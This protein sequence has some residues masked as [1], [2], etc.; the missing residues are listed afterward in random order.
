MKARLPY[1]T[2]LERLNAYIAE[3]NMRH[4]PEREMV[5]TEICDMPQPF[6]ADK[7]T[8]RCQKLRLSQGTV[9]NT[10]SLFVSARILHAFIRENGRAAT[11]YELTVGEKSRIQMICTNC[12]RMVDL[13]DKAIEHIVNAR[14]YNNFVPEHYTM[15]IYG[16]CKVC[17]SLKNKE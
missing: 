14:K 9:Y 8:E 10:L 3:H 11:E 1:E 6:K 2:A 13:H 4:T 17:R 12:G 16:Q 5:L 7:L 15:R